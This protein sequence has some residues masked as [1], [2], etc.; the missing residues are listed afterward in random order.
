MLESM[1]LEALSQEASPRAGYWE[2]LCSGEDV[3]V[4]NMTSVLQTDA[5]T[6]QTIPIV[7]P[8]P[9]RVVS[10]GIAWQ[11]T[12]P[13]GGATTWQL[14]VLKNGVATASL[15]TFNPFGAGVLEKFS[16]K[17]GLAGAGSTT[18]FNAGDHLTIGL[19]AIFIFVPYTD[20][21]VRINLGMEKR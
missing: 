18:E 3:N 4:T 10:F 15:F 7:I 12:D 14:Q 17:F 9:C 2:Y 11:G 8:R 21:T 6:L 13:L 5:H 20:L 1:G 16:G 19:P